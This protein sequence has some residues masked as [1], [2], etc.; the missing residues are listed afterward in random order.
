MHIL[1]ALRRWNQGK[2]I[3]G[4]PFCI[5]RTRSLR[6]PQPYVYPRLY[7]FYFVRIES[8]IKQVGW[9]TGTGK[10]Y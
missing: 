9:S 8:P 6:G 7:A 2:R 5:L 4:P 3:T 1:D 10:A